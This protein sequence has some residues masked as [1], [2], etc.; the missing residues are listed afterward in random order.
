MDRRIRILQVISDATIGGGQQHLLLLAEGL[1][2]NLFDVRVACTENGPLVGDLRG[3]GISV[4]A[5]NMRRGLS[6]MPFI[7]LC[8]IIRENK[9]D[10]IHL[11]GGVAGF[12]GRLSAAWTRTPV[13]IYTLHGIHYLH[14]SN[15]LKRTAFILVERA[16]ARVTDRIICVAEADRELG[17]RKKV[18]TA[19]QCVVIKNGIRISTQAIVDK[20]KEKKASLGLPIGAPLIGTVGRLHHQKGQ[21]YLLESIREILQTY[22]DLQVLLIGDGPMRE[23]LQARA[24]VLGLNGTVHFLGSRRDVSELI[25][26]M[27][28]FVLPSLWEGLPFSLLEALSLARPV[29]AT[30]TDG[31]PEVIAHEQSG[32]LVPP[33]DHRALSKAIIQLLTDRRYAQQLGAEGRARVYEAFDVNKMVRETAELYQSLMSEE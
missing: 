9:I 28:V 14:Y 2:K 3:R 17:L 6:P 1:D 27:D 31:I 8:R 15:W 5:V 22:P 33:K 4:H 25:A 21:R 10:I 23:E 29:V 20:V 7:E 11:H 16:L 26:V 32:L 19:D 24:Q 12:W 13:C 18:F 30:A